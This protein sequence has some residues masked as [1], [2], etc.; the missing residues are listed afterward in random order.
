MSLQVL[1]DVQ[2]IYLA[3]I[4]REII[5][6]IFGDDIALPK[7]SPLGKPLMYTPNYDNYNG[8]T[9]FVQPYTGE[10][11]NNFDINSNEVETIGL[12]SIGNLK[13]LA[14]NNSD[15][16]QPRIFLHIKYCND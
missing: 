8:G 1:K 12:V 6:E 13:E 11:K 2:K 9:K 5:E 3:A 10:H 15:K 14:R 16:L 4:Q 7:I